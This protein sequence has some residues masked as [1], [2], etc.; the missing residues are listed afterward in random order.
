MFGLGVIEMLVLLIV[1]LGGMALI[2]GKARPGAVAI[3]GGGLVLLVLTVVAGAGLFLVAVRAPHDAHNINTYPSFSPPATH[4]MPI[5]GRTE[6]FRWG[7]PLFP[8]LFVFAAVIAFIV[9]GIARIV[10]KKPACGRGNWW[11]A[12]LLIPLFALFVFWNVRYESYSGSGRPAPPQDI[13]TLHQDLGRDQAEQMRRAQAMTAQVQR[14]IANMDIHQLMDKFEQVKVILPPEPPAEQAPLPPRA[15]APVMTASASS[16]SEADEKSNAEKESTEAIADEDEKSG[17]S[18]NAENEKSSGDDAEKVALEEPAGETTTDEAAA[19]AAF[20]AAANSDNASSDDAELKELS[21]SE[22]QRSTNEVAA[23]RPAWVDDPPMRRGDSWCEVI[24]TDEYATAEECRRATDIY[25]L[26]KAY[27]HI[28]TLLGRPYFA[29]ELPSLTFHRGTVTAD[30][31]VIFRSGQPTF[32]H[33][34]RLQLLSKIGIGIDFVRR[35]I[36]KEQ[37]LVETQRSVGP[38]L[39]QYTLVEFTPSVDSELRRR[40]RSHERQE[41]FAI[42]GLGAGSVLG[43]L[44]LVFGLLKV[45]TWTKGY[46][47]K[48]LFIGVPGVIIVGFLLLLLIDAAIG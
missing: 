10:S 47:T 28:Q 45:D 40:W 26:M 33:D 29:S 1:L 30:G 8:L 37:R 38:M 21:P 16:A 46:Y 19:T 13:E 27:D 44:G 35:E 14:Q 41:R 11:P 43:L 20:F 17:D 31:N 32:W 22:F 12:V 42:V 23:A 2:R 15:P 7:I 6:H 3:V 39:K 18:K 9:T 4:E 36:V 48:R 24:A 25:L 5:S 34:E